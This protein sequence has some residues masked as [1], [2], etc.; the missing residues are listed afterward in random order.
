MLSLIF[1]RDRVGSLS[2]NYRC[3]QR[4]A[5]V[6]ARSHLDGHVAHPRRACRRRMP[7]DPADPP[8]LSDVLDLLDQ[9]V[10]ILAGFGGIAMES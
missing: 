2:Y 4:A 3:I 8:T 10:L 9:R 6:G 7:F 1:Q 5:G